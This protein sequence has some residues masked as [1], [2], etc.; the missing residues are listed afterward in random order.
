MTEL[1]IP[2]SAQT[3]AVRAVTDHMPAG[4]EDVWISDKVPKRRRSRMIRITRTPGGGMASHGATDHA[5]LIIEC[6]A[7]NDDDA[8][9]LAN[10]TRAVL[11]NL[12]GRTAAGGFIR[13]WREDGGPYEWPDESGQARWQLTGEML[14]KIS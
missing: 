13:W 1:A 7:D 14:I 5:R 12:I 9:L 3:V 10:T 6:W 8:E 11:R 4:F 2:K